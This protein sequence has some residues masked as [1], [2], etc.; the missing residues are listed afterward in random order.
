M[1]ERRA[2]TS[3]AGGHCREGQSCIHHR[4]KRDDLGS[5]FETTSHDLDAEALAMLRRA[6]VAQGA[7]PHVKLRQAFKGVFRTVE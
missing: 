6:S 7:A 2:E 3:V 4:S 1:F 5:R